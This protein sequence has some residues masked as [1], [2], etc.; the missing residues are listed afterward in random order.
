MVLRQS[1]AKEKHHYFPEN[2]GIF[3]ALSESAFHDI[4]DME[5]IH[6]IGKLSR[7]ELEI[8]SLL[9]SSGP[10][11]SISMRDRLLTSPAFS[12]SDFNRSLENLQRNFQVIPIGISDKGRWHYAYLYDTVEHYYPEKLKN[13]Y[14]IS[15]GLAR[16]IIL[17]AYLLS[18]GIATF[19]DMKKLLG[20]DANEIQQTLDSLQNAG[21]IYPIE[22]ENPHQFFHKELLK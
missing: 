3:F 21:M 8:Y 17:S 18:I 14:K 19:S 11:D 16:E 22:S 12:T 4:E 7:L 2:S 15:K 20:W 13:A 1:L 5:Y 10:L 6:R 9:I